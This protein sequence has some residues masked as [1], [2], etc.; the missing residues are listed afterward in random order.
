VR[1]GLLPP[2][3]VTRV[4][5]TFTGGFKRTH[6]GFRY[7]DLAARNSGSHYGF[8]EQGVVFSKLVPGLASIVI[9]TAGK[10]RLETW[11]E[12]G[13]ASLWNVRHARQNG[14][15]IIE[16]D[17]RTGAPR[18]GAL[19]R[20][21]GRGNWSGS[22]DDRL[23][24]LRA[25]VCLQEREGRRFLI[26]GYFSTAT[27]SAM[28]RVFQAYGCH[29]AV[30]LDMNALEHTYLAVYRLIGGTFATQHLVEGMSV[31]DEP[32]NQQEFPRFVAYADNRDFFYLVRRSPE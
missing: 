21:W 29:Y 2:E 1:T 8:V 4:A 13:P 22:K 27:P 6:A 7:G 5:A 31:L 25:G 3:F 15:S 16:P 20:S 19:V 12:Q 23:R 26:Y 32:V 11:Q 10:V 17:P 18:P 28:A 30:H 14:V 24:S 9:D